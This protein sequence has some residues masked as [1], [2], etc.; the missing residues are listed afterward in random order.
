MTPELLETIKFVAATVSPLLA[1]YVGVW[2]GLKQIRVTKRLD[3]IE[4]QLR[5]F[6][7]MLLGIRKE[8]EAK[9]ELRP[10]IQAKSTEVWQEECKTGTQ[11]IEMVHKE[12]EYDNRQ[13]KEELFPLYKRMLEIFRENYWLAEPETAKCYSELAE[14]VEVWK[15]YYAGSIE[16]ETV[17]KLGHTEERLR[18]F[19][20]E[21]EYRTKILRSELSKGGEK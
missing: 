7:S 6:Y 21:L 10:R 19:Y 18:P 8:I 13:F 20:A 3:F 11:N 2:Y 17:R 16:G 14:Y 12:I 15:R 1:G 4:K 9:S 5:D